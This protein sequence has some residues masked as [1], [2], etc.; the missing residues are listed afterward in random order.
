MNHKLCTL[1]T[2]TASLFLGSVAVSAQ[3]LKPAP[4]AK[5]STWV[6]GHTPDGQPD[7]QGTWTN[8]TLIPLER[9]KALGAKEFYTEQEKAEM[10]AKPKKPIGSALA[11][12]YDLAQFGLDR[13]QGKFAQ[14]LR[15]SLI[16]G[17]EGR[18]P[19]YVPAAQK[20]IAEQTAKI[21]GHEADGPEYRNLGERCLVNNAAGPPMMPSGY[22]NDLEI[23]QGP[24]YVAITQEMIH[25][26]R[27]IRMDGSPHVSSDIRLWRG[28]SRGHWE[29]NTLVVDTTNFNEKIAFQASLGNRVPT[30]KNLHVIER[31]TRTG[32]ETISYQFTVE[33]P[34][35]WEKPWTAEIVMGTAPGQ[36]FE[37]ACHEANHSM[38]NL[39]SSARN[40]EKEAA[41]GKK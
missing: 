24:G 23:V 22:N 38:E 15:T 3:A 11:Q 28:D 16:V 26:T 41:E 40:L 29:G 25:D 14:S 39:L 12:H 21:K 36:I 33:D 20:R 6:V 30:T 5:T 10:D 7:L 32:P 9:N 19:A 2:V 27:I 1:I 37:Y 8:A 34:Q 13:S 4:A 35:T 17:P 31:F 18:M